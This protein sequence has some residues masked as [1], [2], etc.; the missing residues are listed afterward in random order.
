MKLCSKCKKLKYES[1]F[2]K[3]KRQ[4]TGLH[5]WCK[6]CKNE[7]TYKNR[8]KLYK[9]K[10]D[11]LGGYKITILNYAKQGEFKYTIVS[12]E[13]GVFNSNDKNKFLSKLQGII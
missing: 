13:G 4:T 1:E 7:N 5:C 12:T 8:K 2:Y 6:D 3:D 11:V 9:P 10:I